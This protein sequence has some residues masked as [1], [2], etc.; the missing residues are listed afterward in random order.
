MNE[1]EHFQGTLFCLKVY[2]KIF[3]LGVFDL[4]VGR[5]NHLKYFLPPHNDL[6]SESQSPRRRE[7]LCL[8]ITS[9]LEI[10]TG[11]RLSLPG[12]CHLP[13]DVDSKNGGVMTEK[14]PVKAPLQWSPL[15][16]DQS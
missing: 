16:D 2:S 9:S 3:C 11:E 13:A 1:W 10:D 12:R 14:L 7:N 4:H 15:E 6:L 5:M 8:K